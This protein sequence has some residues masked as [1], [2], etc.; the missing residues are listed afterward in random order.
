M[1]GSL[2]LGSRDF[3]TEYELLV[4]FVSRI[5][6]LARVTDGRLGVDDVSL[7]LVLFKTLED[8]PT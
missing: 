8:V 7:G 4:E 3:G 2:G 5:R 1:A 6:T